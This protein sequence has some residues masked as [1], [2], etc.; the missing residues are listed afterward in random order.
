[1]STN[2]NNIESTDKRPPKLTFISTTPFQIALRTMREV[3]EIFLTEGDVHFASCLATPKL[4]ISNESPKK[5]SEKLKK[6]LSW[7]NILCET[8]NITPESSP[9]EEN[10]VS[11]P[12][13][14][15]LV[16]K[17]ENLVSESIEI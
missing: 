12:K 10:L 9:K 15:K 4:I 8:K 14:E 11:E 2:T 1:M 13:E 6:T 7:K 5:P 16:P 3:R 17:E